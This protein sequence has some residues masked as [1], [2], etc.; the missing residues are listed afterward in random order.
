LTWGSLT[1]ERDKNAPTGV[2]PTNFLLIG[3]LK[4]QGVQLQKQN[5]QLQ[6]LSEKKEKIEDDA[7]SNIFKRLAFVYLATYDGASDPQAFNE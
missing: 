7:S 5:E 3:L 2:N 1:E 4:K 6:N